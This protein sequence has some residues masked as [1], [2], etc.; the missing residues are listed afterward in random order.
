MSKPLSDDELA[1]LQ[2]C[3][4]VE[5]V[6]L[7][8]AIIDII[9]RAIKELR[10]LRVELELARATYETTLQADAELETELREQNAKLVAQIHWIADTYRTCGMSRETVDAILVTA[11]ANDWPD[12]TQDAGA[13]VKGETGYGFRCAPGCPGCPN[14]EVA[15]M[16]TCYCGEPRSDHHPFEHPAGTVRF[17]CFSDTK[18][19]FCACLEFEEDP[20]GE[21]DDTTFGT[22]QKR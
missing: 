12:A 16:K 9:Y 15:S 7:S 6:T 8:A 1:Y 4:L 5:S 22:Q 19:P 14:C 11:M 17:A 18:D 13:S 20:D 3:P 21:P 2:T 10:E